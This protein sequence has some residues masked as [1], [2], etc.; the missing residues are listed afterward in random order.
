[1]SSKEEV[2]LSIWM[3][4]GADLAIAAEAVMARQERRVSGEPRFIHYGVYRDGGGA[5]KSGT[6]MK[7]LLF[8][9][10]VSLVASGSS[11]YNRFPLHFEPNAGQATAGTQ[12]IARGARYEVRL[13]KTG[14]VLQSGDDKEFTIQFPGAALQEKAVLGAPLAA[15]TNYMIG[16]NPKAWRSGVANYGA[17]RYMAIYPG[18]DIVYY[19]QQG[20]L[21]YDF[22][23]A[24]GV[25]P[26]PIR[27]RFSGA[28]K[29]RLD[30]QGGL[31]FEQ[32]QIVQKPPVA[33][34]EIAGER[35]LVDAKYRI[36][37]SGDVEFVLGKY[38]HS[39]KL[40]IDPTLAYSTY[41]G[42]SGSDAVTSVR[43]DG[44]GAL[45]VTGHTTSSNFRT[46]AGVVQTSYRGRGSA[47]GTL[48]VG[49]AFVAKFNASG[50]L[51]Y[52]TYFGGN[53]EDL[54]TS[55]AID[56]AGN[57]FVAGSTSSTDFPVSATA[58][59]R[60]FGGSADDFFLA[61]GDAFVAKLSPDG[62]QITYATYLGGN[63]NDGAWGI[64]VDGSGN[65]VVVGDTLSSNF[66]TT[67]NAISRNFRG[68]ANAS[69]WASGDGWVAKLNATGTTLTYGSYLGGQ[70]HDLAR[71]VALDGEGNAYICGF[72]FS[73]N[74]PVTP[75]AYQTQFRGVESTTYSN[76]ADD[77]WVMKLSAQNALVYSTFLGGTG[78][79]SAFG[80][81]VDAGGNAYVTGKTRSSNFPVT[82][83]AMKG[84]YGGSGANGNA[85]D[86]VQGDGFIAKLNPAGTSLLYSSFIGGSG[87]DIGTEVA[88]DGQGNIYVAGFTLSSNFSVST[89]ALQRT[90]GGFGG[91][92]FFIEG[93]VAPVGVANTGDAYV[94]KLNAQGAMQYASY[95]GGTQDD[96]AYGLAVDS[97]GNVYLAGNTL[98]PS[99]TLGTGAVQTVYGGIGTSPRGDG[100]VAKFDFGGKLA[101]IP[102]KVAFVAGAPTG[103]PAGSTLSTP[104]SVEV[105][106]GA[107]L[108]AEGVS[109]RFSATNATVNPEVVTT[110]ANGRAST[111]VT[112]GSTVGTARLT[113]TV[114][115]LAPVTVDFAVQTAGPVPSVGGVVNGASFLPEL[116]P[117]SWITVGGT[118]LAAARADLT[119]L[120]MPTTLGGVRV[121]VN[122]TAIPL[123]VV[124]GTQINAQLPFETA[125]GAGTLVVEVNGVT[126]SS[127]PITVRPTAPGI[128]V[129]G[130]NRAV[131]Q[132]VGDDAALT[133]NTAENP[134]LPGKSM[135]V[136]LTG[137][138][139]LDNAVA[140]GTAA[141]GNPLSKPVAA[142]SVTVGGKPAIV[143]FLGMTPGQVALVQANIRVPA[144]LTSGE[145]P[146][147]V[148]IGGQL[149]NGPKI[150]VRQ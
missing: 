69:I 63:L 117:G 20:Q 21:E 108:A 125:L 32:S 110:G 6:F 127:F 41:F 88:L 90:F 57:A 16:N 60:T 67:A 18:I 2:T 87:D 149:S 81:T 83:G 130:D 101:A 11:L 7:F 133:V 92:G 68:S 95:F 103:G 93:A 126:S 80:V 141:G 78:R 84:T 129:F 140:T 143:D 36:A 45:Y 65:A 40:T 29:V 12:F 49:D 144:D 10:T 114:T 31:V 26:S 122:G 23:V 19:G 73:S 145:Y 66:P 135:I 48:A 42:G 96:A 107:N 147:V 97:A 132:N 128:F 142:Y 55:I 47:S 54:G 46:S 104:V 35:V 150:T 34:Q 75:G 105:L 136:Y 131:A 62:R 72:T 71:S 109:V 51:V 146:V 56:A 17:V 14:P 99:L 86:L 4:G 111:T 52:S 3:V 123:L 27:I 59:Q 38:D 77:G 61:R 82:A 115:G 138:G 33:Y 24:A 76:A 30:A 1:M 74:F 102:A 106:D 121:L 116:A 15:T 137:Q 118:N 124:L 112:L 8:A 148:T 91:Q 79:D 139:M 119:A 134:I 113:A 44:T 37:S 5:I 58:A 70:S 50:A 39:K 64:A 22:E 85:N 13:G 120:P 100:F 28:G 43:V 94:L 25:D 89:D 9:M 53:G 98:S